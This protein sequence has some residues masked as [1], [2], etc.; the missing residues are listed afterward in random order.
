MLQQVYSI[1]SRGGNLILPLLLLI[2]ALSEGSPPCHDLHHPSILCG[3]L[4]IGCDLR[5]HM[6]LHLN[7]IHTPHAQWTFQLSTQCEVIMAPS[8]VWDIL[9]HSPG[10]TL[11]L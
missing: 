3:E 8:T 4:N 9:S 5:K 1:D 6:M 2:Y 11:L 10:S 7:Y